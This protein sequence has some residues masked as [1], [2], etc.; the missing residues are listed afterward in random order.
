MNTSISILADDDELIEIFETGYFRAL[1]RS[2]GI[3]LA[4]IPHRHNMLFD[5]SVFYAI[6]T[7]RVYLNVVGDKTE[8]Q[9]FDKLP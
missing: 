4:S 5:F 8:M 9:V 7:F 6:H 3:G 2:I 1:F